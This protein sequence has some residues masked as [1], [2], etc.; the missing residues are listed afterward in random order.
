MAALSAASKRQFVGVPEVLKL[1][2]A[3]NDTYYEGALLQIDA[4][5]YADVPSD[6]A[7]LP[8]AG[9]Y[10]GRQGQAFAVANGSHDEIEVLRGK[11]WVAFSGAAQ[12]DVG[13]LFYLSDDNTLTQTAGSKNWAL[14]CVGFKSGY[15]L[16]DFAN[17]ICL[18]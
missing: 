5:G 10:S 1:K 9:V 8:P 16:V 12:S 11:V 18:A 6:T 13:E 15:V 17:P 7:D 4:D 2:T 14:L 3:G